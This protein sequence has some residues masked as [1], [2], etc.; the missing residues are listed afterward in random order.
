MKLMVWIVYGALL[1]VGVAL[2]WADRPAPLPEF[3]ATASLPVGHRL[4]PG[5]LKLPGG[6][7]YLRRPVRAGGKMTDR[8]LVSLPPA[9]VPLGM[10]PLTVAVAPGARTDLIE[11]RRLA[12]LCPAAAG[13]STVPVAML[14]CAEGDKTCL[15]VVG[16]PKN[17]ARTVA[18]GA[19]HHISDQPCR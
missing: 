1:A 5:D 19:P 9:S 14:L 17:M 4:A 13:V 7:H 12:W 8:D 11:G 16:I 10:E 18:A 6:E 15:A 3:Q 2:L